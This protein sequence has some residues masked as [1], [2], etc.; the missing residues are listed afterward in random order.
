MYLLIIPKA[1]RLES[2]SSPSLTHSYVWSFNGNLHLLLQAWEVESRHQQLLIMECKSKQETSSMQACS[3]SLIMLGYVM[4]CY[5]E[6][7]SFSYDTSS[8]LKLPFSLLALLT[9]HGVWG[10]GK[11]GWV[12]VLFIEVC[13]RRRMKF[14]SSCLSPRLRNTNVCIVI[15]SL[16]MGEAII[17]KPFGGGT[18][19]K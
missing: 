8:S 6:N 7:Y 11:E 2:S 3:S 17:Q 5:G 13:V 1:K 14:P 10:L 19:S 12:N 16:F 4:R 18:G 9:F 15:K